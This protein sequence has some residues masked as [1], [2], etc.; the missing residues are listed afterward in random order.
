MVALCQKAI[1]KSPCPLLHH[2]D[3]LEIGNTSPTQCAL[4]KKASWTIKVYPHKMS[5]KLTKRE[6][7]AEF[8]VCNYWNASGFVMIKQ[9]C[10]LSFLLKT[11]EASK[12]DFAHLCET[13]KPFVAV[14][15]IN[16]GWL[17]CFFR[18]KN[19]IKNNNKKWNYSKHSWCLLEQVIVSWLGIEG[20]SM[21][22]LSLSR[23]WWGENSALR[24]TQLYEEYYDM[25]NTLQLFAF[26]LYNVYRVCHSRIVL[27]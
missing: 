26:G 3:W 11:E 17:S 24:E 19:Q 18:Q 7:K 16:F 27:E 23:K 4:Q 9:V 10:F 13:W 8:W 6:Q 14:H 25:R 22:R 5:L 12:S 2:L 15:S 20:A 21:N 1:F